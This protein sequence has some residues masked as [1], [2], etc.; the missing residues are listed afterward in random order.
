MGRSRPRDPHVAAGWYA[1]QSDGEW[2]HE[3]GISIETLDNPG[4]SVKIELTGT[5]LANRSVEPAEVHRSE[6]D[7]L[8]APLNKHAFEASCGPLN[9]GEVLHVFRLWAEGAPALPR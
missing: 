7:R 9:L 5:A 1:Q 3:W 2:E 8:S 6:H 4:W